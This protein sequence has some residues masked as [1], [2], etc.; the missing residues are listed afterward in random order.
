V[1]LAVAPRRVLIVED[2]NIVQLH[3]RVLLT[4]LGYEVCGVAATADEA[5][6]VAE[7]A[8]PH[9]VLMDVRL[10]GGRD[11]IETARVLRKR[12]DPALLFLTANADEETVERALTV[13]AQG[14]VLKPFNKPQLR[15]ALSTALAEWDKRRAEGAP[16]V[17]PARAGG[18]PPRPFGAGTRMALFSHDTLGLG[19]LQRCTN[20]ARALTARHL[21][22]SV[23]LLTG[24]PAVHRYALPEGVDYVK[25]PSV[26]KTAAEQYSAR[27]LGVSDEG[28]LRLRTNLIL[29]SLQD[30][31]PHV[32]LVDHAPTGMKGELLPAL[33]W[34]LL[35]RP[36]C[37]K[38]LGLRDVIDDP[39]SLRAAW[40]EKG[41]YD[42]LRKHYAHFLVYGQESVFPTARAYALPDDLAA[43]TRYCNY[44]GE[45]E[46]ALDAGDVAPC[47]PAGEKLVVVTIGGGDGAGE[48]V[49]GSY[50]AMLRA[51]G[52]RARWRS[53][54]LPGPFL[55][56]ELLERFR[57][58]CAGLE[59]VELLEFVTSTS[60]FMARADL[61]VCTGGYNT[62]TQMLR[63]GRRALMIPR[64]MHRQEQILR[65]RRL[66]ELGLVEL[67]EPGAVTPEA[68]LERVAGLLDDPRAPLAEAR[69]RGVVRFDG[70]QQVAEF[71]AG[72]RV[73]GA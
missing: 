54:I 42:L 37:V 50:L 64:V 65:A 22:L 7:R 70:A 31:D 72:L 11:G 57:A 63:Y 56:P 68:L 40:Q 20:I 61:V 59:G 51:A 46:A 1:N 8:P 55:Q 47:V 43:R 27:S 4:E 21:G 26:R 67:L 34:L 24:S 3:L 35:Q 41:T 52:T 29:R 18:G 60:P 62:T 44:V 33:E 36:D 5:L 53:V 32:L 38:L 25:L 48:L 71:C 14:Y 9:L 16:A 49:I 23:L 15:A 66:A 13:G 12:C 6:A 69:E 19:H 39:E 58:E 30:Y 2:D 17:A 45:D 10:R 28:V 73:R